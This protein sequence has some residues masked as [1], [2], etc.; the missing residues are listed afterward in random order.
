[1]LDRRTERLPARKDAMTVPEGCWVAPQSFLVFDHVTRGMALLHAGPEE[2]RQAL[3]K[4]IIRA[5]AQDDIKQRLVS[6]GM[7]PAANSPEEFSAFV[8]SEVA[9]WT[10]LIQDAGLKAE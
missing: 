6:L 4:E 10:K 7:E 3:R 5:L 8:A 2:E 9:R 1:M